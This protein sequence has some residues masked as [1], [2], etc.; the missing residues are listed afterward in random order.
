MFSTFFTRRSTARLLAG[1]RQSYER[2]KEDPSEQAT[3]A[4]VRCLRDLR[5]LKDAFRWVR[6]ARAQFPTSRQ[7]EKLYNSI[8]RRRT[9]DALR[10]AKAALQERSSIANFVRV[11]ELLRISGRW[12]RAFRCATR[13]EREFPEAWQVQFAVGRLYQQ[14]FEEKGEEKNGWLAAEHLEQ[15][16]SLN[17]ND[18]TTLLLLAM[19]LVRLKSFQEAREAVDSLLGLAP[20]DTRGLSILGYIEQVEGRLR[21]EAEGV[22]RTSREAAVASTGQP[23]EKLIE[24]VMAAPGTI[25]A[26]LFDAQKQVLDTAIRDNEVFDFSVPVEVLEAVVAACHLDTR[27]IGLG[28]L[29]SCTVTGESWNM[30]YRPFTAGGVLAFYQGRDSEDAL[31]R[32]LVAAFSGKGDSEEVAASPAAAEETVLTPK[33]C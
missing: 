3:L 29:V 19:V 5:R 33:L 9:Q 20:N 1:L 26:F 21:T 27:R 8:R 16:R 22:S 6:K 2:Y 18:Y 4:V 14:R 15:S 11:I 7:A 23:A 30:A 13:A 10:I 25:G 31:Q 12:R 24:T 32:R 28:D 17:P